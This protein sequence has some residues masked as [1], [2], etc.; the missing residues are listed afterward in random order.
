MLY[1]ASALWIGKLKLGC[2]IAFVFSQKTG[3]AQKIAHVKIVCEAHTQWN[4]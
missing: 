1:L 3:K 4:F 2:F